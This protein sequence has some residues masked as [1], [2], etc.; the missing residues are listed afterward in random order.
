[1]GFFK[2]FAV[3]A[4]AKM[5]SLVDATEGSTTTM[6]R[7]TGNLLPRMLAFD[8]AETVETVY[9]EEAQAWRMLGL[10][11][12]CEDQEDGTT[13][14]ERFLLWAAY[15]DEDY[16][17]LG[18]GEYMYY[19]SE[20]ERW[21]D[22]AC[23]LVGSDRCVK[24]DCHLPNTHF[25]LLGYYKQYG[26]NEFFEQLFAHQGSC[27]W[28]QNQYYFMENN[29]QTWPEECTQSA[30]KDENGA[31]VYYD[32]VPLSGGRMTIGLYSDAQCSVTYTGS[33]TIEEAIQ[34]KE[35]GN[36]DG[37]TGQYRKDFGSDDWFDRWNGALDQYKTCQPCLV[38]T[39]SNSARRRKL[40]EDAGD[41]N[42]EDGGEEEA[43]E[44]DYGQ[45]ACQDAAGNQ[46]AN[47]CALFAMNTDVQPATFRDVRLAS[48]QGTITQANAVGIASTPR[49]KWW[50]AWGFFTLASIVFLAGLIMF[51]CFVKVKR[52]TTYASKAANEPLLGT[53]KNNTSKSTKSSRK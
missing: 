11:M 39:L 26:V 44:K 30:V 4:L 18:Q 3:F 42:G 17:G 46:G 20:T 31:Y 6:L 48:L 29:R 49:Q 41:A 16:A 5:F 19:D 25:K 14:C 10:Y 36:D 52:R 43:A 23:E 53:S 32:I 33:L 51:C 13:V 8:T 45:F 7:S 1:M 50:R 28:S 35:E 12:D 9:A 15:V 22:S 2:S 21:N 34:A 24:M 38:S 47:Q 37:N 40:E 27:T